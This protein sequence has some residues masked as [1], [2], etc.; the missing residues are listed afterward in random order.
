MKK[1]RFKITIDKNGLND[2]EASVVNYAFES[3]SPQDALRRVNAIHERCEKI[4]KRIPYNAKLFLKALA[5]S[6]E[7]DID[8]V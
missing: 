1:Q 6:A 3:N 7:A 8:N 5:I 2:Y 4:G